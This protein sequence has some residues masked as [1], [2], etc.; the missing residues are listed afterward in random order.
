[1]AS[2]KKSKL[3][4][5][6]ETSTPPIETPDVE[7]IKEPVT[8]PSEEETEPS[9]T[10]SEKKPCK[11]AKKSIVPGPPINPATGRPFPPGPPGSW[12]G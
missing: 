11:K 4:E 12:H 10:V 5:E 6:V 7:D 9:S 3:K 2:K 8:L 1:M